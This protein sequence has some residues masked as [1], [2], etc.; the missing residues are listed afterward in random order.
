MQKT[1]RYRMEREKINAIG[2][3]K[4][5]LKIDN[6]EVVKMTEWTNFNIRP[7]M[8]TWQGM[9]EDYKRAYHEQSQAIEER[10]FKEKKATAQDMQNRAARADKEKA[11]N[12][13]VKEMEKRLE[14]KADEYTDTKK[15][16]KCSDVSLDN[17]VCNFIDKKFFEARNKLVKIEAGKNRK[18]ILLISDVCGWAWWNKSRYIQMYLKDQ[19]DID[20]ICVLGPEAQ[21]INRGKYDLFLT[22][23]YSYVG[24]LQSIDIKKRVTGITAHRPISTI[25]SYMTMAHN[26]HAN[27]MMLYNDLKSAVKHNRV[28]YVPN[29][30]DE[31]I[32]KPIK[33]IGQKK[34]LVAGHVGKKCE[35]KGQ[36]QFIIPAM[37]AADVESVTNMNDYRNRKPFCEM[38]INYQQMDVFIVASVEDGTPNGALEAAACGRPIISNAIGNMPEFIENG[39][40]G[41]LV[42]RNV[43]EYIEKLN[44]LNK[45]RDVLEKMGKAARKTV[46][47]SWT[48]KKQSE[49]YRK[50]FLEI[51]G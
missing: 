20:V 41:F 16:K 23:G 38:H 8:M 4:P 12:K 10:R 26:L 6:S 31:H 50:M 22:Y 44:Y 49:G 36:E 1:R 39:V 9:P 11:L 25:K 48:W 18:R 35:A 14:A 37:Q 32:F 17:A 29:G 33:P 30:V 21:G 46:E 51:L 7:G 2:L 40:N 19:F 13:R 5:N 28:W 3:K 34:Q 42:G 24:L 15:K 47:K 43:E 27:S 45:N